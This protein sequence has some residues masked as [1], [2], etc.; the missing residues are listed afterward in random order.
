VN[1]PRLFVVFKTMRTRKKN[2]GFSLI[3]LLIVVAI[4]L[5]V[6][7][8]AIPNL[9]RSRM[10]ANQAAAVSTLRNINN[11][12][13]AYIASFGSSTGYADTLVKLGQ[14]TPCD[15]THACMLDELIGCASQPCVKTGYGYFLMSGSTTLPIL[16]YSSTATPS[17]MGSSGQYN[18]CSTDD[19]ILRQ[20]I[21]PSVTLASALTHAACINAATYAPVH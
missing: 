11:S 9:L 7:A 13:A 8:I 15:F 4:I 16:D 14:G 6:A 21:T 12:Q 5:I 1:G 17:A 18:Y 2:R 19:G 20:E 3:E 10:S